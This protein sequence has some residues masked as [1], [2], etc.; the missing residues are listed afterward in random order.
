M[1]KD[2]LSS[3]FNFIKRRNVIL[4]ILFVLLFSFVI[5]KL[6]DV[7]IVHGKDYQDTFTYRIEKVQEI[8]AKRGSI[9][10]CN[11]QLLAYDRLSNNVI[12]SDIQALST[13]EERNE[14]VYS[15]MNTL[16][17]HGFGWNY[18]IPLGID[19]K[20][21]LYFTRNAATVINFKKDIFSLNYS[22]D[23]TERQAA[24]DAQEVFSYIISGD[25]F[26]IS[27]KY[28]MEE[29]LN[30]ASIRYDMFMKRYMQYMS[31]TVSEDVDDST[32]AAIKENSADLPG[33][34][35]EQN[36][37]REYPDSEYFS[38][39][40]GYVGLITQAELDSFNNEGITGYTSGDKIGK[41]GLE[42]IYEQDLA[43][44]KGTRRLFVNNL[45][46]VM[47][48]YVEEEAEAGNDIYLNIDKELTKKI[49]DLLEAKI[50][51][52][53]LYNLREGVDPEYN[54]NHYY[55]V[56][57][58]VFA[59]IE[60]HVVDINDFSDPE[61]T[62]LE[63]AFLAAKDKEA[64][65]VVSR[66]Y[67][68]LI[69]PERSP[70]K[71]LGE[72]YEEYMNIIYTF[73]V[74]NGVLDS[75]DYGIDDNTY[76]S[77][78]NGEIS[79][80]DFLF[81]AISK[82]WIGSDKIVKDQPYPETSDAYNG[83]IEYIRDNIKDD[84]DFSVLT[85]KYLLKNQVLSYTDVCK[86]LYDQGVF[87]KDNDYNDLA[88]GDKNY[89]SFMYQKINKLEIT[90]D[91]LA[92][93]T[94]SASCTVTDVKTGKVTALVSYPSYN[95]A[96][97]QDADYFYYLSVNKSSPMVNRAT[98]QTLAPGSTYKMV[99]SAAGLDGGFITKDSQ[100]TDRVIFDKVSPPASC[101]S[102]VS[103]GS[104]NVIRAIAV[105][106]NYFFYQLGF[107]MSL[108]SN[109]NFSNER[110]LGILRE[111]ASKFGLDETSGVELYEATPHIS[112]ESSVRSAIGQGTNSFTCTQINRYT[113]AIA[114]KGNVYSM[115][116]VD[117]ITDPNGEIIE[118]I[119]P[120][121]IKKVEM[122]DDTWNTIIEG[123]RQ[124]CSTT[125][126]YKNVFK[127]LKTDIC[128]KTGTAEENENKPEH[129][130]M[131][132]FDS[133]AD[134]KFAATVVFPNGYGSNNVIDA[135]RDVIAMCVNLPL[136]NSVE[137][138]QGIAIL[139]FDANDRDEYRSFE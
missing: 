131:T 39:L 7:Q 27:D 121:I 127:S 79:L 75:S 20:G 132:G 29:Q 8:P 28:T 137:L 96:K 98:Q 53:I 100:I 26:D 102:E 47:E 42:Q 129:A 64:E 99:T 74:S 109:G 88:N 17:A 97:L 5:I 126:G 43:G 58:V 135:F 63:K 21:E 13:N 69:K 67:D 15:L 16:T 3:M 91:M 125:S 55:D 138:N 57:D 36:Y 139:P 111:Y 80:G 110:G 123:M 52:I 130:L 22:D 23:L 54:Q 95:A 124:V 19:N 38:H 56:R 4:S 35:I 105:S 31:V 40:T 122:E 37:I 118:D 62:D 66:I 41:M 32:V 93:D 86:L 25:L 113:T 89:N 9:Y 73:L 83:L 104:I 128:G 50:A 82:G 59:L 119:E 45:G 85:Y 51:G 94:C 70:D 33:V 72:E 30:I 112:D 134:P 81:Y 24:M 76:N 106:C 12:I 68:E 136:Y 1:I 116:I 117:K 2:I 61:A 78:L 133:A 115:S 46:A 10:D 101:W 44:K 60:N 103:H 71:D 87:E 48:S 49:Y 108:D 65:K 34:S 77:W 6:Y 18:T 120:E 107:N 114:S 92:L 90:P 84:Y 14:M 11:G